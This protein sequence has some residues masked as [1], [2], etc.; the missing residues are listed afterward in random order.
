ME[1]IQFAFTGINILPSIFLIMVIT[2]W[3]LIILG[4]FSFDTIDLELDLEVDFSSNMY[5]DGGINPEEIKS[6]LGAVKYYSVKIL[7]F[8][9]IGAVPIMFYGTILF[10]VLWALSMLVYYTNISPSSL[11]GTLIF[12]QNFIISIFITKGLTEP[13]KGFF[14]SMEDRSDIKIIGQSCV[15][16]SSLNS[17]NIAQ[18]EMIVNGYPIVINVKSLGENIVKGSQIIVVSKVQGK[19]LYIVKEKLS[20]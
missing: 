11:L 4:I 18:A 15:L 19:E 3:L 5:F 2:Y 8:L 17:D 7:K 12:V 14:D 20:T 1:Y 13:L 6:E 10:L 9:N 16:K